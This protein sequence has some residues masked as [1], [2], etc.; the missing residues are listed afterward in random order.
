VTADHGEEFLDHGSYWH[1]GTLFDEVLQ[2]PLI[3]YAPGEQARS[4]EQRVSTADVFPTVV[5]LLGLP[6]APNQ[7]GRS[8][9]RGAERS[10]ERAPIVAATAFRG[11]L[12]LALIEGD[13]KL[14]QHGG[15]EVV[16]LFD[17]GSDPRETRDLSSSRPARVREMVSSLTTLARPSAVAAGGATTLD[18]ATAQQLRA[19]GY[20]DD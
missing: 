13:E 8:L 19:L 7:A 12:K 16:G 15:G 5:D 9:M 17:L 1:G 18:A 3:V 11:A 4:V 2:V 6:P 20:H 14:I 10:S